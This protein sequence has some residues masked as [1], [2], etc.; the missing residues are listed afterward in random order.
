MLQKEI[1]TLAGQH[2]GRS[3]PVHL[4]LMGG[5]V[6][7]QAGAE[8]RAKLL[9]GQLKVTYASAFYRSRQIEHLT[10][11]WRHRARPGGRGGALQGAVRPAQGG[12][13]HSMK[14]FEKSKS[15]S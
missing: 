6:D 13:P 7:T 10:T 4:T 2:G 15:R 11:V 1:D 3:V 12:P 9:S 14:S 5:V 8:E